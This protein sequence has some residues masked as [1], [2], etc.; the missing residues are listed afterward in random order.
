MP[1][2]VVSTEC[3]LVYAK[4]SPS[5]DPEDTLAFPLFGQGVCFP[6]VLAV[7]AVKCGYTHSLDDGLRS[8]VRGCLM[9]RSGDMGCLHFHSPEW[10]GCSQR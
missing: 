1:T 7:L 9:I 8:V 5:P 3:A 10:A 6:A 4:S 2:P